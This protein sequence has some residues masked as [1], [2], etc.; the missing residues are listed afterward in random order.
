[1]LVYLAA[2][3]NHIGLFPPVRG[4]AS[5]QAQPRQSRGWEIEMKSMIRWLVLAIAGAQLAACQPTTSW[6]TDQAALMKLLQESAEAFNRG[7][8]TGHLES[9]ASS[10]T[11]MTKNGPRPGVVAIEKA[12]RE[13]YFKDGKPKQRLRFEQIAARRLSGD[14]ALVTG[15]FILAGGA[16]P[17][18]TGWFTTIWMRTARGWKVVHDHSS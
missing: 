6:N 7:D 8:L 9:Y 14:V 4:N 18:Q 11:F 5:G 2:F 12:F 3:K 17:D 16:D 1:M 10:V 13:A 15:R